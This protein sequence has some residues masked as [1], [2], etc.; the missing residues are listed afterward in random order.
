V[1]YQWVNAGM[2]Y[3]TFG[4]ITLYVKFK[5][6]VGNYYE[7]ALPNGYF[8]K[9]IDREIFIGKSG[10]KDLNYYVPMQGYDY[11]INMDMLGSNTAV[12]H[13]N[14]MFTY[15]DKT[16]NMPF[17]IDKL[18]IS[19]SLMGD[20][21]GF[22]LLSGV[23]EFIDPLE[24]A[25]WHTAYSN[26]GMTLD[27]PPS[28]GSSQ[29]Y[30]DKCAA[31]Q[32]LNNKVLI[33]NCVDV[34]LFN[35]VHG[36]TTAQKRNFID[37]VDN[38]Y[39]DRWAIGS[40]YSKN[41]FDFINHIY[42]VIKYKEAKSYHV[43]GVSNTKVLPI[44]AWMGRYNEITSDSSTPLQAGRSTIFFATIEK[45]LKK[46][47]VGRVDCKLLHSNRLYPYLPCSC[48]ICNAIKT[49][50]IF[51]KSNNSCIIHVLLSLHNVTAMSNYVKIWSDIA[52][53]CT[54][55]EFKQILDSVYQQKSGIWKYSIDY[56][57]YI[58]EHSLSKA[59]IKFAS[60]LTLFDFSMEETKR[61][62]ID[63]FM[64]F[65]DIQTEYDISTEKRMD[66][67]ITN[68]S[69]YYNVDFNNRIRKNTKK[70]DKKEFLK[71]KENKV[72]LSAKTTGL[73]KKKKKQVED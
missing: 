57:E 13:N 1:S 16:M 46:I 2:D 30:I 58:Q 53:T 9:L 31:I 24:L 48:P 3:V 10:F 6:R 60:Y 12:T 62:S 25:K 65:Q 43:F 27:L 17:I 47:R 41:V 8:I 15:N 36:V 66:T 22:Q 33:D 49:S 34:D 55:K 4:G 71:L 18:K 64:I 38:E 70:E 11:C 73:T 61:S 44:L 35:I 5:D 59:N 37:M 23:K 54:P 32:I 29:E 19:T 50:E 20:S 45:I 7:K 72:S 28:Y 40:A 14:I 63:D 21:G 39:M 26:L 56:I 42:S 51:V 69:N 68:Y 67:I 52:K